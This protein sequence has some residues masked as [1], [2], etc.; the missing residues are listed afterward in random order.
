M[1]KGT[2][3]PYLA[4][5]RGPA[6]ENLHKQLSGYFDSKGYNVSSKYSYIL[7]AWNDWGNNMI[8]NS[9][10]DYI[11]GE[12][13]KC[14]KEGKPFPLHKYI[15]HGLSSQ[16]LLFNLLGV[17][18]VDRRYFIFDE[19]LKA[20]GVNATGK[21][22]T[23]KLEGE[24]RDVF[25]ETSGQ[26]TS[27]DIVFDTDANEHYFTEFKFTEA[28]FGGCSLFSGGD[29]DGRNPAKNFDMCFLHSIGRKYWELM[30][31]HSLLT[32]TV[33]DDSR[34]AFV[35]LYQ[36]YRVLMFSLEKQGS[37]IL[38]HDERNPTFYTHTRHG[39]RGV[40]AR[41]LEY[42]PTSVRQRCHLISK[43]QILHIIESFVSENWVDEL[44]AKY[45]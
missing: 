29:C 34:C 39:P 27:I 37:F 38:I 15:H 41:F 18:I 13:T 6:I 31:K 7:A 21:V 5:R 14:M 9:V 30:K 23:V 28:E 8:S 22:N 1:S 35:D 43:Q 16:A 4:P 17:F 26:P 24:D 19:I 2:S 45:F 44:K 20:A 32:P 25:N 10:N 3:N 33:V 36:A 12:Q 42:L 40:Y 11:K